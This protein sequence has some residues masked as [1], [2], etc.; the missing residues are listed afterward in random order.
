MSLT[1]EHKEKINK[2]ISM[3]SAMVEESEGIPI[4]YRVL[5]MLEIAI[6]LLEQQ[7][8]MDIVFER[9]DLDEDAEDGTE[10]CFLNNKD[11]EEE[12]DTGAFKFLEENDLP[13]PDELENWL[14]L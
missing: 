10:F 4:D 9:C 6:S 8:Q 1:Q 12:K 2:I 5:D 7:V 14:K 13:S 3:L 11:L